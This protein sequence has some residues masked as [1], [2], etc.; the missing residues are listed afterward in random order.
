MYIY[1][2]IDIPNVSSKLFE[3]GHSLTWLT[4]YWIGCCYGDSAISDLFHTVLHVIHALGPEAWS[5]HKNGFFI[6]AWPFGFGD[7][8]NS[9]ATCQL[10]P[11]TSQLEML[12]MLTSGQPTWFQTW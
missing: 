7:V 8:V 1:I 11:A 5:H 9:T 2:Y 3:V 12:R 4:C 6:H 10:Q